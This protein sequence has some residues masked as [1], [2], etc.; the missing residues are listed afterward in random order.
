[1]N[2]K[3]KTTIIPPLEQKQDRL[4]RMRMKYEVALV[5]KTLADIFKPMFPVPEATATLSIEQ[6]VSFIPDDEVIHQYEKAIVGSV[7]GQNIITEAHFVGY[8]Y[9]YAVRLEPSDSEE[10]KHEEV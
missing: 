3:P 7:S 6:T 9:L 4:F 5:D 1:M 8:D 2:E 10:G